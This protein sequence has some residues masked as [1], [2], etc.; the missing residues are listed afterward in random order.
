M[1]LVNKRDLKDALP[2]EEIIQRLD[3]KE[4]CQA[5]KYH[6]QPSVA[7][8]GEGLDEG[9]EWLCKHMEEL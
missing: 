8:T 3:F 9:V 7:T 6:I 5:R 4:F 1:V 2:V